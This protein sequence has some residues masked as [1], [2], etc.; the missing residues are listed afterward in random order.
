[1]KYTQ[2]IFLAILASLQ[3]EYQLF[4]LRTYL[5][6]HQTYLEHTLL[7]TVLIENPDHP[8]KPNTDK[9]EQQN[10]KQTASNQTPFLHYTPEK[11]LQTTKKL[12]HRLWELI[13]SQTPIKN[14]KLIVGHRNKR[15]TTE[16]LVFQRLTLL[17]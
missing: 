16:E 6:E 9:M 7:P 1:M 5:L 2:S 15:N 4:T 12:I 13:F 17:H 11:R 8:S 14:A 3:K 10:Y